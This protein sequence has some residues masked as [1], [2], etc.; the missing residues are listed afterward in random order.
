MKF[1]AKHIIYITQQIEVNDTLGDVMSKEELED[2]VQDVVKVCLPDF[3]IAGD[4]VIDKNVSVKR[5][6]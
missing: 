6:G 1:E 5:V 4:V 2:H 3:D